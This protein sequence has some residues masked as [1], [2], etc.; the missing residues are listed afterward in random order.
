MTSFNIIL[1]RDAAMEKAIECLSKQTV[2]G[3]GERNIK[4]VSKMN[5]R[6]YAT[7]SKYKPSN[8]TKR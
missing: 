3:K 5:V 2:G 1:S 6:C 7:L 8:R 4:S